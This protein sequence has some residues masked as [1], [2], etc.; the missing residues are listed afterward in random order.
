MLRILQRAG[1]VVSEGP[2]TLRSWA[3]KLYGYP[4]LTAY[5][6]A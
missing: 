2:L 6:L 4:R 1:D 3:T 5:S